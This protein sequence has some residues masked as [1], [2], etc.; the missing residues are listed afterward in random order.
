MF[1]KQVMIKKEKV[2]SV[3]ENDK[4]TDALAKFSSNKIDGMPVVNEHDQFVGLLTKNM[5]YEAAFKSELN[6]N[7]FLAETTAGEVAE[8][9]G[10][11]L[12]VDEEFERALLVVRDLPIVVVTDSNNTWLGIVTRYDVLEQFQSAFG[13]KRKGTRIAFTSIDSEGRIARLADIAKHYHKNI[14]S[15]T[16]FDETDKLIRRI[17]LKIDH[18]GDIE[19]FT[20][21]LE[22]NGF[23]ILSIKDE[24]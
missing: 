5:I 10:V 17:V 3:K 23:R 12:D 6:R 18:V 13:M 20:K 16:T 11:T 14:I 7:T 19:P 24:R 9:E 2:I 22:K 1:V 4:L 21:K 15:L 8:A